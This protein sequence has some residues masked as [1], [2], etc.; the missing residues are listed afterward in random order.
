MTEHVKI[1]I[2]GAGFAGLGTAIRMRQEGETEFTIFE[3]AG[4]VGGTWRDNTYPGAACDVQ[5]HLY[6]FSFVEQPDWSR[7]YPGQAEILGNIERMVDA[8]GIRPH[9]RFHKELDTAVWD[10]AR[11]RWQLRFKDGTD[12]TCNFLVTGWGQL[13]RPSTRDIPGVEAFR[14]EWFHSARWNHDIDLAGKRVASI[15]NGPSA[16][17]FIPELAK[18]AGHLTVFQRSPSYVVPRED[19]PYTDEEREEYRRD[20]E[21]RMQ[22]RMGYYWD[23]ESWWGAMHPGTDK[24]KEFTDSAYNLLMSQISDPALREKLWPNYPIGCKRIVISDDFLPVFAR[25]NVS[26]VTEKL[27]GIEPAGVRTADGTL[28]EMDVIIYGT[29][30]DTLQFV[31]VSDVIGRGGLSLREEWHDVPRAYLGMTVSGFPNFFMLYGPN[32]NL[33]HN[34]IL[35]MME[36]QI[37]YVMRAIRETA[38]HQAAAID[39]RADV[40]E[41]AY[42]QLQADLAGTSWA[43]SCDSWYKTADGKITNNWSGSVEDYKARTGVFNIEDYALIG[44]TVRQDAME[45]AND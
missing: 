21:K 40:L 3:K 2:I 37:A 17:Q 6:W 32:T 39:L 16:V 25:P 30:F 27:A 18:V 8:E 23:H 13:N 12:V 19:R 38:N 28:H 29:G 9:I 44:R 41:A 7:V 5:S 15:G 45:D 36:C 11:A 33:G 10:E 43:G 24:A 31:A 4:G 20:R 35:L 14:G 1:A 42:A 26:L 22:S 34:S